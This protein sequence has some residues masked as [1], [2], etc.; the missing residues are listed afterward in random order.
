[1][2]GGIVAALLVAALQNRSA[3]LA[4]AIVLA[5]VSAA[6]LQ[7]NYALF[8]S[9][10]TPTFVLLAE[11]RGHDMHLA[12]VR[13]VNSILG[14]VLAF[15]GA[16][17]RGPRPAPPPLPGGPGARARRARRS[18]GRGGGV[19]ARNP[20]PAGAAALGRAPPLR[21]RHQPRRCVVRAPAG[22]G[23]RWRRSRQRAD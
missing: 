6:V 8:S 23:G 21:P 20:P 14:G 9:L 18:R 15:A 3:V 1:V 10:I 2:A 13:I 12:E 22:R 11:A 19:G 16:R 4:L 7:L 17:P 5:G